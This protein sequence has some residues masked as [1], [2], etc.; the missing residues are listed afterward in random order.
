MYGAQAFVQNANA[1][2]GIAGRQVKLV[3]CD[4]G[5][6]GAGNTACV[7]KLIDDDKVFA[8]VGN[9]IY[10]YA[11][12]AFVDQRGVPDVGGQPITNAYDQYHHLWSIY[13]TPSPRNGVVGWNGTLSGGTEVYHYFKETLG[14]KTAG[15]VAYNQSDSLRFAD[16][17]EKG[18]RAE[19]YD[20]VTE[21]LDFAVPSWDAAAID[22]K[23]KGVDVVFDALDSAGNVNLCKAMDAA[24]LHVKAKA[25]T[26]Q[27]WDESVRD[28]YRQ[29]P[30]CRNS[31]YA[32]GNTRNYMDISD[33]TI[34]RFR[35]DIKAAFPDRENRLSMW[36]VEGWASAQW[37]SD[38]LQ[39][40][41]A[42][43][44]RAC[45]EA[46]LSRPEPYDGH[47]IL[48]PRDFTVIPAPRAIDHNCLDAAKWSDDA[49]GGGGGWLTTTPD[50]KPVCYDVPDVFY[51][52]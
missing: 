45:V 4:D 20:V 30:T 9:S 24:G 28:Q 14:A 36:E 5:A 26:V 31:L 17:T 16:L 6:T 27:S 3:V 37:L 29:S 41:P 52:P 22:M 12:A 23:A 49:Y 44:T 1:N 38:A 19:G 33:P 50:G 25:V 39:T 8:F 18:L 35:H 32:T 46:Y 43:P 21:Q 7:K 47:G 51:T 10:D 13:G 34:A 15:V 11:G 42:A 2:G 40:C 48:T